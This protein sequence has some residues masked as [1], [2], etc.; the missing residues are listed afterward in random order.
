[1]ENKTNDQ[2]ILGL[3]KQIEEKKKLLVKSQKFTPITNCSIEI[4][5]VRSNIQVL[6][7]EQLVGLLVRLNAYKTSAKELGVLE[8]YIISSFNVEDWI[9]DLKSK[10]EFTNRKDEEA[11]L[12]AMETKLDYLLSN[13]KKVEL[14]IDEIE[15]MLK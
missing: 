2:K 13:E 9:T 4:D 1:M 14:E 12:K 10:L 5:G 6:S 8:N 15:S 7:K 11:K 3:K